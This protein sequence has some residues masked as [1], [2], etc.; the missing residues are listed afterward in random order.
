[1]DRKD[2]VVALI[3]GAAL[4]L[5]QLGDAGF[6]YDEGFTVVLSRL[7]FSRMLGATA[8]DVHPPFY[9][10]ITWATAKIS[11]AEWAIRFPSVLFSLAVIYL[12]WRL[13]K[14]F[15][16]SGFAQIVVVSWVVISPL[17]LHYAQEARMYALLQVQV[18]GLILLMYRQKRIWFSILAAAMLYTHNYGIFYLPVL[19][20]LA[21]FGRLFWVENKYRKIY[22]KI[23]TQIFIQEWL[24]YFVIP[25]LLWIPWLVVMLQQMGTISGGYW[26]QP[27]TPASILFSFYQ[28]L[29]AYS[30]PQVFQGI[31]V[32]VMAALIMYAAWRIWKDTPRRWEVLAIITFGPIILS[33]IASYVWKPIYLFRG[34]I[35]CSVPLVMLIVLGID[36]I[37]AAYKKYYLATII[38]VLLSAG[39]TGHFFYNVSNKGDTQ[40]WVG[41]ITENWQQG[42]VILA[43]NDNGVMAANTYAEGFPYFKVPPCGTE[44]LGSLSP[45]TRQ[46]MGVIEKDIS[47]I[48]ADRI[49]YI[50]TVAPVSSQCEVEET[51]RIIRDYDAVLV[52]QLADSEYRE[53]GVYLI[54]G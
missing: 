35:G 22:P 8:G 24:P 26:L 13:V 50:S 16:F 33:V 25:F 38:A 3:Y 31:A 5:F 52:N 10:L 36:Q 46:A 49:W 27:P 21:W 23:R 19:A 18:L 6:W 44:S 12:T 53:A 17:Q 47:E 15:E 41:M 28:L 54:D 39:M 2:L 42:D 48:E 51:R 7:P 34:L 32:I 14:L 11:D 20:V 29:F 4:R 30:M 45:K 43:L 1:M 40:E 37:K 9:Y